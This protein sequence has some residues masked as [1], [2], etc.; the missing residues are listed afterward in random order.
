MEPAAFGDD[1]LDGVVQIAED[2]VDVFSSSPTLLPAWM[3]HL[4]ELGED[5][6]DE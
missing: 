6:G 3:W 1:I 2:D 5:P 4:G